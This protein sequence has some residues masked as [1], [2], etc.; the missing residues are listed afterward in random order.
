[1]R[2]LLQKRPYISQ[3]DFLPGLGP[4]L[5]T[6]AAVR[7][8]P[9]RITDIPQHVTAFGCPPGARNHSQYVGAWSFPVQDDESDVGRY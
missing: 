3:Y 2:T 9:V 8:E 1:M 5:E 7:V 6:V 4:A